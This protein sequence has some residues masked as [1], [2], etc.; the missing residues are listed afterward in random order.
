MEDEGWKKQL[1][2]L[3]KRRESA[4]CH[5]VNAIDKID[6]VGVLQPIL[7]C[8]SRVQTQVIVARMREISGRRLTNSGR[9]RSPRPACSFGYWEGT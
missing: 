9:L 6:L 4:F 1:M 3:S 2:D 8:Y 7:T 5:S